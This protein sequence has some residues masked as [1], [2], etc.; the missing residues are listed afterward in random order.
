MKYCNWDSLLFVQ[1]MFS[2]IISYR[3]VITFFLVITRLCVIRNVIKPNRTKPEFIVGWS[4]TFKFSCNKVFIF[5]LI[6]KR[7]HLFFCCQLDWP[8]LIW[9]SPDL[10]AFMLLFLLSILGWQNKCEPKGKHSIWDSHIKINR[11]KR[12]L[13]WQFDDLIQYEYRNALRA[14]TA[15]YP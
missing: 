14:F 2:D 4:V 12:K 15:G 8:N 11:K 7:W 1:N 10:H 13:T 6:I 5:A 3:I 9:P